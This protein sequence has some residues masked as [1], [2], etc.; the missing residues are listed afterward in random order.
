MKVT[1]WHNP[2]CGSSRAALERLQQAGVKPDVY[3]YLKEKPSK[4][5]IADV[6]KKLDAKAGDLL[7]SK[8]PLAEELG[9]TPGTSSA[10]LLSAMAEHPQLIQR[11]IVISPK[12][13][14]IA[15]PPIRVDEVL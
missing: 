6:L 1:I 10:R 2:Q 4:A 8:E 13:A 9:L 3:L 15:R 12:G 14:V 5:I 11:P 7:R